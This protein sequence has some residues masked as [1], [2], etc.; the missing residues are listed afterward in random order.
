M[1]EDF[2]CD[3]VLSGKTSVEKVYETQNVLAY[4]HTRPFYPVHIVVIPKSHIPSLITLG[5]E[6]TDILLELLSVVKTVA[7]QV[8][9][10]HGACRVLTNLGK[11]QDS[12]HLHWHVAFGEPLR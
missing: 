2:Y 7:M 1:T 8:T 4:H 3:A 10:E 12:K 6:D 9:N 11:Y 5:D